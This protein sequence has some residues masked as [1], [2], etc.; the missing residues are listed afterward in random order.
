MRKKKIIILVIVVFMIIVG[1]GSI[2]VGN[3]FY[4]LSLNPNISKDAVFGKGHDETVE[5]AA[6][7]NNWILDESHYND[8]YIESEDGLKL[9]GY[10]IKNEDSNVWVITI[11]GYM[12]KG[13]T[14]DNY[15]KQFYN[16]GYNVLVPDLR[17]HGESEGDYIGMGWHDHYDIQKWI[18]YIIENNSDAEIILHGVSMGGA[19]VMMTS[20]EELPSNVKALIEDCGYTSVEDEFGYQLKALFNLP[21]APV[22]NISSLVTKIRAGYWFGEASSIK[23]LKKAKLPMLFIHGN[24]DTFVPFSMLD[25]VYDAADVEKEKL[26]IDGAKHAHAAETNPEL[27]WNTVSKFIDKYIS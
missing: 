20:G 21:K 25:E 17:G 7:N 1:A 11:H 9:H 12:N 22:L 2:G 6:L 27:Y 18:D 4:N 23:Q 19:T 15:A 16:M 24:E 13:S 3:Y 26:V 8:K 5:T 14:M 10:E